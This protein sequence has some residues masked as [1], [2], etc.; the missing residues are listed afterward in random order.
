MTISTQQAGEHKA[1][2]INNMMVENVKDYKIIS[3]ADGTT[4]LIIH[5]E[6]KADTTKYDLITTQK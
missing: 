2:F 3:S 5:I 6:F 4:E 1:V